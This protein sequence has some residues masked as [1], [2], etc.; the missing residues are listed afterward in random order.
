VYRKYGMDTDCIGD[1]EL[2]LVHVSTTNAIPT[3]FWNLVQ[4]A[5]DP[6]LTEDVRKELL[7]I[8]SPGSERSGNKRE[9]LIDITKFEESCPVLVSSYRET[10]RLA[11]SQLG[12]RRVMRDT[13]VSD[14]KTSYLL[15]KGAN[16]MM[17]SGVTHLS[18]HIWGPNAK[19]FDAKRF[20]RSEDQGVVSEREKED[21]RAKKRAYF[22]FGGGKHLCPGR[23]FAFAEI[24]GTIAVLL[25]GFEVRNLEGGLIRVPELRRS[26]IGEGVGK[27]HPN[28]TKMGAKIERRTGWEDV[29]WKFVC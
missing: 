25:L 9:I 13:M 26:K 3:L 20:M 4:I 28:G 29:V 23:N 14:G 11:N 1:F 8:V 27:P 12:T 24:L 21:D 17:P 5:A 6:S 22:P 2:A 15:R 10:I 19:D 16:V 7:T 18:T